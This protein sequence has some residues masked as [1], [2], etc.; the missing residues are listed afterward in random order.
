MTI[1]STMS[2]A[3][4]TKAESEPAR[5]AA[6]AAQARRVRLPW[7]LILPVVLAL[8]TAVY[9]YGALGAA[10][11]AGS[12]LMVACA[13][14]FG[15]VA[16]QLGRAVLAALSPV[17]SEETVRVAGD[18]H[19]RELEREKGLIL[20]AIKELEFDRSMN[21]ISEADY[22]EAHATYRGRAL[23]IMKQLDEAGGGGYREIIER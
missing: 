23:R 7:L 19:R 12:V 18:R 10:P 5:A 8:V 3:T 1:V 21:K 13:A 11:T 20:K 2:S 22:H 4:S 15:A 14:A 9:L 17:P 16:I 6:S